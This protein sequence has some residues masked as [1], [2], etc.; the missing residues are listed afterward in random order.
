MD[1]VQIFM[2]QLLSLPQ[3]AQIRFVMPVDHMNS[4]VW[5][6]ECFIL[7]LFVARYKLEWK[8]TKIFGLTW[9]LPKRDIQKQKCWRWRSWKIEEDRCR[10]GIRSWQNFIWLPKSLTPRT[11]KQ[12]SLNGNNLDW[13]KYISGN[14]KI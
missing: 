6:Q 10:D 14:F 12:E 4:L 5:S 9:N 13:L 8:L 2:L 1:C 3:I 11:N 7:N